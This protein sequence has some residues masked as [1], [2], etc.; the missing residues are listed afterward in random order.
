MSIKQ[1]I[2]I[3]LEYTNKRKTV[4]QQYKANSIKNYGS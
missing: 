2:K 1:K 3:P 4:K